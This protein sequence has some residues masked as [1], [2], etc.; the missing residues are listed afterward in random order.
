ML[1]ATRSTNPLLKSI[2]LSLS[3]TPPIEC[4]VDA[5][6][7]YSRALSLSLPH[8]RVLTPVYMA[9]GTKGAMKGITQRQM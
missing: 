1:K 6:C 9:V 2:K 5:T 4:H 8:G 3:S 7:A